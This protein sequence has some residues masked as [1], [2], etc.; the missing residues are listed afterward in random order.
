M[1][2]LPVWNP[3]ETVPRLMSGFWLLS[4]LLFYLLLGDAALR[5]HE[6]VGPYLGGEARVFGIYG[7]LLLTIVGIYWRSFRKPFWWFF[8]AFIVFAGVAVLGDSGGHEGIIMIA[9]QRRSYEQFCETFSMLLLGAGFAT[10][11]IQDLT[12]PFKA[13]V[14]H[15]QIQWQESEASSNNSL[16]G[17]GKGR[18]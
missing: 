7:M 3:Y 14:F 18:N 12:A 16:L 10:E 11:A 8:L 6:N 4:T 17:E 2:I 9:G 15:R 1:S 13:R 5:I